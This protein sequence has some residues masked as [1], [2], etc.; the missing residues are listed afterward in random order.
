MDNAGISLGINSMKIAII[1]TTAYRHNLMQNAKKS[2]E[3][4]GHEVRLP[5]F[6]GGA[7][8]ELELMQR[9]LDLIR[10]ADEVHVFW[11]GRSTGT[12]MDI[13]MAFALDK[14]LELIH[15]EPMSMRGFVKQ[16][17]A[18]EPREETEA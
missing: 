10:W 5:T 3:C 13:A 6:D 14:P 7:E 18:R 4:A 11:D 16:Y 9:N 15:I 8:N 17:A 1:G 2:L 12:L